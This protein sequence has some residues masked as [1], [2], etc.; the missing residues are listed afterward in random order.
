MPE[1]TEGTP[2]SNR[3]ELQRKLNEMRDLAQAHA[4]V[5]MPLPPEFLDE[6]LKLEEEIA[7]LL[8]Y[9]PFLSEDS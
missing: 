6:Y 3:Q 8:K 9:L 4:S 7:H 5:A 2:N 1:A